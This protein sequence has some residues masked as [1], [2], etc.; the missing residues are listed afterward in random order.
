MQVKIDNK[1]KYIT[2]DFSVSVSQSSIG[3]KLYVR[4]KVYDQ[5]DKCEINEVQR[6]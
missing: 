5:Y 6:L 2:S 4:Y 1:W 3:S